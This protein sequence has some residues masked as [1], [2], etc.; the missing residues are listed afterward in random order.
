MDR[1][2]NWFVDHDG[3]GD[4]AISPQ[5]HPF[6]VVPPA[7]TSPC[8][9]YTTKPRSVLVPFSHTSLG[10]PCGFIGRYGLPDDRDL[11]WLRFTAQGRALIYLGDADPPDLLVFA[12]LRA[13]LRVLYRG[14][15]DSLLAECGVALRDQISISQSGS[16]MAAMPLVRECLPDLGDLLGGECTAILNS[17]RKIE[18]EAMI[19]FA[20]AGPSAIVNAMA[21]QPDNS[22]RP[23]GGLPSA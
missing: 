20:T 19:S 13:H 5:D 11:D 10:F 23:Q 14:L 2:R 8:I 17:G 9:L 22:A 1:V 21:A 12:W 18:V 6:S 16:E 15:N 7:S 4:F 3:D